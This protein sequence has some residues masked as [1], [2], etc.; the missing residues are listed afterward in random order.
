MELTNL[1]CTRL[2][3]SLSLSF[4]VHT[5]QTCILQNLE[6]SAG[7]FLQAKALSSYKPTIN[8]TSL[9]I[10][11]EKVEVMATKALEYFNSTRHIVLYYED[12]VKNPK[13]RVMELKIVTKEI[14][15]I[16]IVRKEIKDNLS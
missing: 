10:D 8:S 9:I 12:L 3:R 2:K 6:L 13:V 11:L 4:S 14:K 15:I 7:I 16:E 5:Q 1:M